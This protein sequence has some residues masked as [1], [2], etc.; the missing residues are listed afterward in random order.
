MVGGT[1]MRSLYWSNDVLV[2]SLA[3]FAFVLVS[4]PARAAIPDA[5]VGDT[6][7]GVKAVSTSTLRVPENFSTIQSAVNAASAGDT[8]RISPGTFVEQVTIDK[9]LTLIGSGVDA[10]IIRGPAVLSPDSFGKTSI[11]EINGGAIVRIS[12]LT[13]S[14]PGSGSCG[15]GE[16]G[17]GI[18]VVEGASL[19]LSNARITHIHDTPLAWCFRAGV[20]VRIG[21][22]STGTTGHAAIVNVTID[23]YQFAGVAV[24]TPG[25]TATI[26]DNVISGIGPS[27][28]VFAYG[29]DI[30]FG[31]VATVT[32]NTISNNLCNSVDLGCGPDPITQLQSADILTIA[33]GPG[34]VI[35]SNTA[36]NNDIGVY[37]LASAGSLL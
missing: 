15:N 12:S 4:S 36:S 29:I 31:A 3:F 30:S 35:S 6:V 33:A 32:H 11:V 13:V 7:S 22:R 27:S 25:S 8:I 17:A 34:T 28:S 23:D 9:D 24:F 1:F 19:D 2:G 18:Y 37:L 16:L 10:T 21:E 14:G 5:A 26:S 20:G